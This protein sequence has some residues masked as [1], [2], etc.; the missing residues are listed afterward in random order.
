R[1]TVVQ[2]G[3]GDFAVVCGLVRDG[4]L[5][6]CVRLLCLSQ[7]YMFA[8]LVQP[9]PPP[10]PW[11]FCSFL[12]FQRPFL[13]LPPPSSFSSMCCVDCCWLRS[14]SGMVGRCN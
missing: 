4:C 6:L 10:S 5:L 14:F 13:H 8:G 3:A 7:I 1:T 11:W 9:A 2:S 12:P